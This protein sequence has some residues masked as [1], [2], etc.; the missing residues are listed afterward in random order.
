LNIKKLINNI[1]KTLA[2]DLIRIYIGVGLFLKGVQFVTTPVA[3]STLM[4]GS[5]LQVLPLLV[6]HYI[7][8]AHLT[9]GFMLTIGILTRV[10]AI[11]QI[12]ILVGA[13]F[14]INIRYGILST[15]QQFEFSALVLFLLVMFALFGPGPLSIDKSVFKEKRN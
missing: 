2:Y 7:S 4:E 12:P 1:D 6:I 11:I 8:L 15:E 10:A 5:Q 13:T 14:L 3:L 9:G